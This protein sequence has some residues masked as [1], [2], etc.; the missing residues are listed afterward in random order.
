M[1]TKYSPVRRRFC[2]HNNVMSSETTV[3]KISDKSVVGQSAVLN[4][5]FRFDPIKVINLQ[6]KVNEKLKKQ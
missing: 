1:P 5:I 3:H 4:T 6:D 2:L